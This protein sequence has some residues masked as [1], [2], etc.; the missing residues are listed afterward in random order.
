[1]NDPYQLLMVQ[2][3]REEI[4][5]FN[6]QQFAL[7]LF[8]TLFAV[9]IYVVAHHERFAPCSRLIPIVIISGLFAIGRADMLMHRA[10]A[11]IAVMDHDV[12]STAWEAYKNEQLAT[13]LLPLYDL[14]GLSVW[15]YLFVWAEVQAWRTLGK[16]RSVVYMAVTAAL[17]VLGAASIVIGASVGR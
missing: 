9:F 17:A 2:S 4:A 13:K 8:I 3:L 1:M 7:V 14:F 10:G 6:L 15:V 16:P 11:Y 12:P 5:F